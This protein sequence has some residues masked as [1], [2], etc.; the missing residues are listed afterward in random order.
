MRIVGVLLL[1]LLL[2]SVSNQR[3][4]GFGEFVGGHESSPKRYEILTT[5]MPSLNDALRRNHKF[6]INV[7]SN[8]EYSLEAA[9]GVCTKTGNSTPKCT[10]NKNTRFA[11]IAAYAE[12]GTLVFTWPN[13][14]S[15]LWSGKYGRLFEYKSGRESITLTNDI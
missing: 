7:Y 13:A 6:F 9:Y 12:A 10:H 8:N 5:S 4:V 3:L 2:A 14:A 15:E 1:A 11:D